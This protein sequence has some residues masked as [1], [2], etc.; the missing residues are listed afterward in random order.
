[1]GI[2][3]LGVAIMVILAGMTISLF[4]VS[5]RIGLIINNV[6]NVIKKQTLGRFQQLDN[7]LQSQLKV[8]FF[9]VVGGA[10]AIKV[11]TTPSVLITLVIIL[12][13][14]GLLATA[15]LTIIS[16]G[17]VGIQVTKLIAKTR[18]SYVLNN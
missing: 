17:Y 7:V 15:L 14:V 5:E 13:G 6:M 3:L 18:K 2:N 11:L 8:A 9:S 4:Y 10:V 16:I 12:A 1:M